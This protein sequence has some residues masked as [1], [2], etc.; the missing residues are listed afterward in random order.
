MFN[1]ESFDSYNQDKKIGFSTINLKDRLGLEKYRKSYHE[2][3][4]QL[5]E[6]YVESGYQ[7]N[8]FSFCENEGDLDAIEDIMN[9]LNPTYQKQ[10]KVINYS[11]NI[12]LFIEEFKTCEHIIGS[13]L[14]SLILSMLFNKSFYPLIYSDKT[15]HILDDLKIKNKGSQIKKIDELDIEKT[16]EVAKNNRL[17]ETHLLANASQQ[18]LK[19]DEFILEG[20]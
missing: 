14:H 5:I 20:G 10:V 18:L 1:Y 7:V 3:I 11:G 6:K 4:V 2:K 17:T 19:I 9:L 13:R 12:D 8:L 16:I 15:T